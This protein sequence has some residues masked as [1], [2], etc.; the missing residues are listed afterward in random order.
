VSTISDSLSDD[1]EDFHQSDIITMMHYL[2]SPN[3]SFMTLI[4]WDRVG[5][6]DRA[7]AKSTSEAVPVEIELSFVAEISTN[8]FWMDADS[9]F[10]GKPFANRQTPSLTKVKG[11]FTIIQPLSIHL[12]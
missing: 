3:H 5:T 8:N 9:G 6:E 10:T 2:G 4:D 12:L 7:I 1:K 11:S